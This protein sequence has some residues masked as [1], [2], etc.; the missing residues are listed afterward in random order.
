MEPAENGRVT[1]REINDLN[2]RFEP[3]WS[4]AEKRRGDHAGAHD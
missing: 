1:L 4:P 2:Q 3:Q